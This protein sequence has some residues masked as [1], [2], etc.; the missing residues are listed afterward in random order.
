[1]NSIYTINAYKWFGQWVFDDAERGLNKEAFVAGIDKML[2]IWE[3][4]TKASKKGLILNISEGFFP[5]HNFK[6][7]WVRE[8]IVG[9]WY[10]SKVLG[11]QGWLCPALYLF[12]P[13]APK[14][15]Y[16]QILA[17]K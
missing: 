13:K 15:I 2:D 14:S 11:F 16:A 9:N 10:E 6:I 1:M 7:D 5:G 17:A 4:Q 3:I 12:F 8:D